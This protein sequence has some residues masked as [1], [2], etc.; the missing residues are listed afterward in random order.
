MSSGDN[1]PFQDMTFGQ[2]CNTLY[3]HATF[4][5]NSYVGMLAGAGIALVCITAMAAAVP[6]TL[7]ILFAICFATMFVGALPGILIDSYL[8]STKTTKGTARKPTKK[9]TPTPAE[10]SRVLANCHRKACGK[11]IKNLSNGRSLSLKK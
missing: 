11:K 8:E 3:S 1:T 2:K 7:T 9:I 6:S 5:E 4:K 10:N